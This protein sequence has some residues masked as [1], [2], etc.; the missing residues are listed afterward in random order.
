MQDSATSAE[1]GDALP[2]ALG[3]PQKG[4]VRLQERRPSINYEI[5]SPKV[6]EVHLRAHRLQDLRETRA[7]DSAVR[8]ARLPSPCSRQAR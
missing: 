8:P 6:E 7:D 1:N 3:R 4:R 5:T 2:A